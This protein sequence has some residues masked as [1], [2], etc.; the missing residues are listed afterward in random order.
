MADQAIKRILIVDDDPNVATVLTSSLE[1]LGREYKVDMVRDGVSALARIEQTPYD[2]IVTDYR[3]PG[4]DG[5]ELLEKVRKVSPQTRLILMTAYGSPD[6]ESQAQKLEIY[7]YI[8]KPFQVEDL[9]EMVREALQSITLDEHGHPALAAD[10]LEAVSACL[11]EL[12]REIGARCVLLADTAGNLI[13]REGMLDDLDITTLLSLVAGWFAAATAIARYL[14]DVE[15]TQKNHYEGKTYD[16]YLFNVDENHF[17]V[18]LVDKRSPVRT[19]MVWLY[20]KRATQELVDLLPKVDEAQRKEMLTPSFGEDL[21]VELEQLLAELTPEAKSA[22]P[23][24][25]A[26]DQPAKPAGADK[27]LPEGRWTLFTLEEAANMGVIPADFL[28]Q[29]QEKK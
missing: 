28:H 1:R 21:G 15:T 29:L 20:T 13:A 23:N 14:G 2:L 4:I 5:L 25:P 9:R 16:I 11:A 17:I 12:R 8:T 24:K 27:P 18:S 19:G 22:T 10:S 7:R 3:M 26:A 6:L